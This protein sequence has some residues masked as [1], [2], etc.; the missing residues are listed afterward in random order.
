MS[1]TLTI[2]GM[3]CEG[4][5]DIITGALEDVD[6]VE[7]VDADLDAKTVEVEGDADVD[8]LLEAVEYAGYEAT[9]EETEE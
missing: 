5:V 3:N 9:V 8:D 1:T 2:D 6:G 7:S 4:C